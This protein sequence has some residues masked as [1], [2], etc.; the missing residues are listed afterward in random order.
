M[1]TYL[2]NKGFLCLCRGRICWTDEDQLEEETEI[3]SVEIVTEL[4]DLGMTE[5][6]TTVKMGDVG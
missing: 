1:L 6:S 4:W 3:I 2:F 5:R